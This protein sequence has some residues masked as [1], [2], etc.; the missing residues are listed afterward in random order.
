MTTTRTSIT[1]AY[2]ALRKDVATATT[3]AIALSATAIKATEFKHV[4]LKLSAAPTTSENLTITIN[5]NA[6][7]AYDILLYSV[8]LS[9]GSTTTMVWYPDEPLFLETGDS[10]DVAYT[11]TD[12]RTYGV[13][14]TMLELV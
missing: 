10:I 3:G 7:A 11:N 9:S 2:T 5:A 1:G 6:G 14:I 13:Q 12:T 4:S 8:D